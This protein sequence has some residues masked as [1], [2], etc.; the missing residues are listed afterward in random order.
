[1]AVA[2]KEQ[3]ANL[4]IGGRKLATDEWVSLVSDA[5]NKNIDALMEDFGSMLANEMSRLAPVGATGN[6]VSGITLLG[7]EQKEDGLF[8]LEILFKEEYTDYIDKGVVGLNPSKSKTQ[9]PNKDGRKYTFK[10]YGM[11]ESAYQSLMQWARSKNI[12]MDAQAKLKASNSKRK[13]K[14][15]KKKL[16]ETESGAK[17]LAYI[18]KKNGIKG[19]NFQQRAYK[20]ISPAFQSQLIDRGINSLTFKVVV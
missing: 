19:S 18:I 11:P 20:N 10:K 14:S 1:M 7:V 13:F 12:N 6:L 5:L 4:K 16:R 15:K 17:S 2:T 3:V 9:Y 8:R